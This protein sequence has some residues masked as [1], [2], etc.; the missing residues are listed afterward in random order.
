VALWRRNLDAPLPVACQTALALLAE[1]KPRVVYEGEYEL[2][3]EVEKEPC[4]ARLWPDFAALASSGEWPGVAL[5]LYGGLA[6]WL[7]TQVTVTPHAGD[8]A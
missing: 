7:A 8:E 1:G 3:G 2:R 5:A 4:L 6:D